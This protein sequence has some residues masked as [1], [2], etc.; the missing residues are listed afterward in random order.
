MSGQY[1]HIAGGIR[2][3]AKGTSYE[4]RDPFEGVVTVVWQN[5]HTALMKAAHG[6]DG[7]AHL[8]ESIDILTAL[9]AK[10]IRVERAKNHHM[11]KPWRLLEIGKLYIE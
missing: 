3:Y 9:G 10:I 11:P 4:H 5:A 1:F 2:F 7:Y 6:N 8:L